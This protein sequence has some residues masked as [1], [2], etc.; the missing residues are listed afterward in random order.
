MDGDSGPNQVPLRIGYNPII[1]MSTK[2]T[3]T[4]RLS[5]FL[6]L[7]ITAA[8]LSACLPVGSLPDGSDPAG[9]SGPTLTPR[10]PEPIEGA[11]A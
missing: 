3:L 10:T 2:T 4:Q 7:L 6:R 1:N 8:L 9:E 11:T 5:T